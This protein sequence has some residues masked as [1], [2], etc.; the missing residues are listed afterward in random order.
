[1]FVDV[2]KHNLSSV[3]HMYDKGCDIVFRAQD[4]EIWTTSIGKVLA[5]GVQ[6]E[7]NVYILKEEN[8]ECYISK[9]DES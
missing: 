4:Y 6:I 8:E 9:Q 1:M 3:S 2:L 5:K 7:N